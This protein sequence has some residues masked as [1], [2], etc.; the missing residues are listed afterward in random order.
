MKRFLIEV[1]AI[2]C[3]LLVAAVI[4]LF[5]TQ[6]IGQNT[7]DTFTGHVNKVPINISSPVYG[8]I[9]TL[10]VN[11]GDTVTKGQT[12]ATIQILNSDV[13]IP[14]SSDLFQVH[15]KILSIQSPANGIVGQVVLGPLST[16]A[17]AGTLMQMYS[18]DNAEIQILLPQ[19]EDMSS[20]T[21][22]YASSNAPDGR[23]YPLHVIGQVPT[24][25]IS[26]INPTTTVYR[27]TCQNC[28]AIE[29]NDAITIYAQKKQVQSPF[30]L[31]SLSSLWDTLMKNL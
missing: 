14:A 31:P 18:A 3:T 13:A 20:Y 10:P 29:N 26:N 23:R 8:Q 28:Q 21:S 22:F 19:G 7:Y 6:N 17:G 5:F 25:V 27:A 15:G 24:D 2:V 16:I 30:P 1:L 9:V 12:L 11:E 4:I